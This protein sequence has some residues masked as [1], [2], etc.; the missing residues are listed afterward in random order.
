M[1]LK[2]EIRGRTVQDIAG[3]VLDLAYQ[4]LSAR[5]RLNGAG[6]N[7]TGFLTPLR[8]VGE[9]GETPAE[10]KLRLYKGAWTESVDPVFFECSY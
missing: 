9:S 5:K 1:G 2:A 7:E 8:Q 3:E 10:R 4:G 6:D